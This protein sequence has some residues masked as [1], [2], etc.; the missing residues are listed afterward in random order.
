VAEGGIA[1]N[2]QLLGAGDAVA[3]EEAATLNVVA[4][5]PSQVLLFDLN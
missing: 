1:L 2:G 5:K 4:E 3:V